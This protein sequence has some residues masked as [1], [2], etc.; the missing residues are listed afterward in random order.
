MIVNFCTQVLSAVCLLSLAALVVA[1]QSSE[2]V[3]TPLVP[4]DA[5]TATDDSNQQAVNKQVE[6]KQANTDEKQT[7]CT[8]RNLSEEKDQDVE[9][10]K[11]ESSSEK[12]VK[13]SSSDKPQII[14]LQVP[15]NGASLEVSVP[16]SAVENDTQT[17]EKSEISKVNES[18]PVPEEKVEDD[19]DERSTDVELEIP[20]KKKE[21]KKSKSS[22]KD[23]NK[24]KES[25]KNKQEKKDRKKRDLKGMAQGMGINLNRKMSGKKGRGGRGGGSG[26]ANR[27]VGRE[28]VVASREQFAAERGVDGFSGF[29]D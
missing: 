18:K 2:Q 7:S 11:K 4:V 1:D 28:Q 13:K 29:S 20:E 3:S 23:S 16:A 6:P 15:V 12:S 22:K 19:D 21:A 14:T 26:G 10:A 24:K 8:C 9:S 5:T 25:Y 17:D 27:G